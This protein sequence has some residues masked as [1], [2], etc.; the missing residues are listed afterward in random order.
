L[1]DKLDINQVPYAAE[2]LT[3]STGV[4]FSLG[5]P[6]MVPLIPEIL[7][8]NDMCYCLVCKYTKLG[9][10]ERIERLISIIGKRNKKQ[11]KLQYAYL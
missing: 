7:L 1:A 5:L 11:K 8:I 6:P 2:N 4:R 10:H 3:T 9:P